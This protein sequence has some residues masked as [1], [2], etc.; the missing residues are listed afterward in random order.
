MAVAWGGGHHRSPNTSSKEF[1]IIEFVEGKENF[2]SLPHI[3]RFTAI[4]R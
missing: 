2:A 1:G 3:T 4:L